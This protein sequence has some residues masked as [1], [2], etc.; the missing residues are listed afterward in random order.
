MEERMLFSSAMLAVAQ[1]EW[2]TGLE[3]GRRV[4]SILQVCNIVLSVSLQTLPVTMINLHLLDDHRAG[5][6]CRLITQSNCTRYL[7]V[8]LI[9]PEIC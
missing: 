5:L 9:A 6:T 4:A 7:A 2:L 8:L 1:W 3:A